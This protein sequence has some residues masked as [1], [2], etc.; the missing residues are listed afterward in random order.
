MPPSHAAPP[1]ADDGAVAA[2][3]RRRCAVVAADVA[4]ATPASS[5]VVPP[6]HTPMRPFDRALITLSEY[7]ADAAYLC[8][9]GDLRRARL[10]YAAAE[11]YAR[12]TGFLELMQLVW[13]HEDEHACSAPFGP[14]P[15]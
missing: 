12:G 5:P 8:E 15:A 6:T 9:R 11:C 4:V 14:R 7:L 13:A 2:S 1:A 10:L 3:G